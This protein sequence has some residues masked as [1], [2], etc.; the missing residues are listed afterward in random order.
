MKKVQLSAGIKYSNRHKM[1][2]SVSLIRWVL[3][4]AATVTALTHGGSFIVSTLR[5][6][7]ILEPM[8][9]GAMCILVVIFDQGPSPIFVLSFGEPGSLVHL[10]L[11]VHHFQS[12]HDSLDIQLAQLTSCT[13]QDC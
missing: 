8:N 9:G 12:I 2:L 3:H 11:H 5:P 10:I 1:K 4:L 13:C 6:V 7:L